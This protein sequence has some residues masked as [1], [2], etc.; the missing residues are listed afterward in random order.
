MKYS[1]HIGVVVAL[2]LI[3]VCFIPWVYIQTPRIVITGINAE[4]TNF[5]RPG[6]VNLILSLIA[7]VLFIIPRIWAVRANI[8]VVAFNLSWASRNYLIITQCELGECPE[9]RLGIYLLMVLSGILFLMT[10]VP[11]TP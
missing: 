7:I 11:R 1:N 4:Q 9:K 10:L 8:F 2:A 5:G 3:A 6:L